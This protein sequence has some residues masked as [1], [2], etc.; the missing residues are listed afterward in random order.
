MSALS[1]RSPRMSCKFCNSGEELDLLRG[2]E[3]WKERST[4]GRAPSEEMARSMGMP[5]AAISSSWDFSSWLDAEDD[6]KDSSGDTMLGT[7]ALKHQ[8]P[9]A[10]RTPTPAM[11]LEGCVFQEPHR[12]RERE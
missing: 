6:C 1:P 4:A 3:G 12:P 10:P 9:R 2:C 11:P 8:A 5:P 7:Q